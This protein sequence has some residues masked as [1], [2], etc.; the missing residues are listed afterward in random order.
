M[1]P[2][3]C[4]RIDAM[5]TVASTDTP[6][7]QPRIELGCGERLGSGLGAGGGEG[8]DANCGCLGGGGGGVV[9]RV[10]EPPRTSEH[11]GPRLRSGGCAPRARRHMRRGRPRIAAAPRRRRRMP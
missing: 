5:A 2:K 7:N 11:V 6:I 9:G 10:G 4:M 8:L 3:R 1:A